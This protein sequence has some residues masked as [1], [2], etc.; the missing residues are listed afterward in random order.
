MSFRPLTALTL[1]LVLS[2]GPATAQ[3]AASIP[4]DGTRRPA[5]AAPA[6]FGPA[7]YHGVAHDRWHGEFYGRLLRNDT[8]TSCCNLTDC[9][10]TVSRTT[11]DHYEVMVDGEWTPVPSSAIQKVIAPDAG[12][13]VCAPPQVGAAKGTLYCVVLPPDG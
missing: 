9:R 13:H 4:D 11:G 8:K 3:D 2:T 1:L 7:G 6:P 5:D 12:A 10:P